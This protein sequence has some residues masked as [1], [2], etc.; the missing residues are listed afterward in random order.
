MASLFQ[1]AVSELRKLPGIGERAAENLAFH[2]LSLPDSDFKNLISTLSEL[3]HGILLC[4]EC[5]L[6][7]EQD[8]CRICS[9]GKR[10]RAVICVVKN[11]QDALHIERTHFYQ[12]LYHVLGG[13]VSPLKKISE[14]DITLDQLKIRVSSL[15]IREIIIAL[16]S[17]V[18]GEATALL[19]RQALSADG[20][21]F[22]RL[23]TGMPH[24]AD[25][26]YLDAETLKKSLANRVAC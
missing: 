23:A 9:S 3:K 14:R 24:G 21:I 19:V 1:R 8:P 2:L 6:I 5:G 10:E 11:V 26:E 4:R 12:G 7:S 13:L 15:D 25:I 20:R 17:T 22:T 16:D 18:E